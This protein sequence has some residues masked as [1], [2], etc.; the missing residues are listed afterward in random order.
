MDRWI[1]QP[2]TA[3]VE[4]SSPATM[5]I[6]AVSAIGRDTDIQMP[7]PTPPTSPAAAPH[8]AWTGMTAVVGD[9]RRVVV[10]VR[11][12]PVSLSVFCFLS[13][14]TLGAVHSAGM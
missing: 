5:V 8:T 13:A 6:I 4:P 12:S 14:P 1:S 10:I 2:T 7:N 3:L 11:S 9:T